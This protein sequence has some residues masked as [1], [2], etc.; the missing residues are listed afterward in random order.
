MARD[1]MTRRRFLAKAA[2]AAAGLGVLGLGAQCGPTPTPQIIE[3]VV[4]KEVTKIVE[5]VVEREVPLPMVGERKL[6]R[7]LSSPWILDQVPTDKMARAYN[8]MQEEVEVR[9]E[10]LGATTWAGA[11]WMAKLVKQQQENKLEWCGQMVMFPFMHL[12]ARCKMGFH[13]PLEDLFA[14]S[15]VEGAATLLDDL[16]PVLKEDASY[17]GHV[18]GVPY[19]YEVEMWTYRKDWFADVGYEEP[20]KTWEELWDA[21]DEVKKKFGKDNPDFYPY[22]WANSLYAAYQPWIHTATDKPYTEEGL[23]DFTGEGL[24]ALDFMKR[25]VEAGLGPAAGADAASHYDL[26]FKELIASF[27]EDNSRA[28]MMA[29]SMEGGFEKWATG[30]MA[31][32]DPEKDSGSFFYGSC[33][34]VLGKAPYPQ[35]MADFYAWCYGPANTSMQQAIIESGKTPVYQSVYDTLLKDPKNWFYA[36]FMLAGLELMKT[37][38]PY[39]SNNYWLIQDGAATKYLQTFLEKG[40]GQE[41][42]E[43]A[44]KIMDEI[45]VEIAKLEVK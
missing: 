17:Q 4:E 15:K 18:Y 19:S 33:W 6:V 28:P 27:C 25:M 45:K 30:R 23:V 12:V 44:K 31:M 14:A 3:K 26:G 38:I 5:R 24:P 11:D 8:E 43:V 35:E 34:T 41:A 9:P 16:L 1:R 22:G 10:S 20:P 37:S 13:V 40:S 21:C 42:E 29:K 32:R 7:F 2:A 39:P 36:E